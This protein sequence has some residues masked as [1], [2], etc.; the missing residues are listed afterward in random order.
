[1]TKNER[2]HLGI[3][4]AGLVTKVDTSFQHFAHGNGHNKLQRLSLKSSPLITR[5]END[6]QHLEGAGLRLID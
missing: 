6:G 2:G 1:M 5:H 3:P 4:E